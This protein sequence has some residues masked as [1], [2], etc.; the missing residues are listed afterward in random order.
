[1]QTCYIFSNPDCRLLASSSKDTDV[2]IWDTVLCQHILTLSGHTQA[3]TTVKWGGLGLLYT[4]S[5]DREI[6]IWRA[7]D[8][9]FTYHD[10]YVI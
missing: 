3:V 9:S 1:M 5:H 4:G 8:V 6:K 10:K 7:K 2:K